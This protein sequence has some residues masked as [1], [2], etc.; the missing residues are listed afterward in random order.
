MDFQTKSLYGSDS[1]AW[2]IKEMKYIFITVLKF[3]NRLV[4]LVFITLLYCVSQQKNSQWDLLKTPGVWRAW[5]QFRGLAIEQSVIPQKETYYFHYSELLVFGSNTYTMC[6]A[7]GFFSQI[8]F[9][10]KWQQFHQK[11]PIYHR[12]Y[13]CVCYQ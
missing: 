2:A 11:C 13:G 9:N 4:S 6:D 7:V 1:Y 10:T 3:Q 12:D 5:A 8:R